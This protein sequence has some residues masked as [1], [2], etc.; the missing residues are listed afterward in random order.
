MEMDLFPPSLHNTDSQESL[1]EHPR[2]SICSA[3]TTIP[4]VSP[5]GSHPGSRPRPSTSPDRHLP[6]SLKNRRRAATKTQSQHPPL[7]IELPAAAAEGNLFQ[8]SLPS[9]PEALSGRPSAPIPIP[10]KAKKGRTSQP[11]TPLTA[12]TP[13]GNY[14][15][16]HNCVH[17]GPRISASLTPYY[18]SGTKKPSDSQPAPVARRGFSPMAPRRPG[19]PLYTPTSP[20]SPSTPFQV[21]SF[22]SCPTTGRPTQNLNLAGLPKFHPANFPSNDSSAANTPRASRPQSKHRHGSNAQQKLHQYQREIVTN[23][24]K[25]SRSLLS[26]GMKPTPPRLAPIGSP[27][28]PM[29]PFMLE[30]QGDYLLA[31]SSGLPSGYKEGDS[32][33]YVERLVR[34][35]NE[36]R[37]HP[38]MRS[39]SL[40][41]AVS[42]AVSPA[43]GHG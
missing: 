8:E 36:R 22:G 25:T 35:E 41:P 14:F 9:V 17:K 11:T 6:A 38:G 37:G 13:P 42:P 20:L 16:F 24:A 3:T 21:S 34:K 26:S 1:Q 31:G 27:G 15:T 30:G 32:R 10:P 23:A 33:D 12:R 5:A 39:E 40:S 43:G 29:T 28:E 2:P 7:R 4:T 18:S 19:S